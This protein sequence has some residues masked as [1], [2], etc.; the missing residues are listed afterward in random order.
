MNVKSED[1]ACQ[2]PGWYTVPVGAVSATGSPL[3]SPSV[4]SVT[5]EYFFRRWLPNSQLLHLWL[6]VLQETTF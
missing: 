5:Q 2:L 3:Q 1:V 6:I 4:D